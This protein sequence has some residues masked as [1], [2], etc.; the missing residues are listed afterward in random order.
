[1]IL[2]KMK[3]FNFRQG[4]KKVRE[5]KGNFTW[6]TSDTALQCYGLSA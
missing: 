4:I 3:Q 6:E 5:D 2:L 1:M